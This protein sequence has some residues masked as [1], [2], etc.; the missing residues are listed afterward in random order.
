MFNLMIFEIY[1][2]LFSSYVLPWNLI[3]E[4]IE[5]GCSLATILWINRAKP[6]TLVPSRASTI[7]FYVHMD[8]PTST[9]AG[10]C[11]VV[12]LIPYGWW[13][14]PLTFCTIAPMSQSFHFNH[15]AIF[16]WR[17][18]SP[19]WL[20]LKKVIVSIRLHLHVHKCVL[21]RL[22]AWW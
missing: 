14:E 12:L 7:Y 8:L 1:L 3:R 21:T 9:D 2:S 6:H 18:L 20:S 22:I 19:S 13:N 11:A 4:I 17:S 10:H 16:L 5:I 15:W